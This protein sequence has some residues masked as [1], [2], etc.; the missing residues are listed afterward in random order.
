MVLVGILLHGICYDFFFVTGFIYVD[1]KVPR[2]IRGQAQGFLVLVTQGLGLG[3]GAQVFGRLVGAYSPPGGTPQWRMIWL[4]PAAF[5]LVV[6]LVFVAL[7]RDGR[8]TRL[9]AE[10]RRP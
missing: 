3:I 4:I 6:L 1:E 5:A 7:F 9:L 8:A 2:E 10:S